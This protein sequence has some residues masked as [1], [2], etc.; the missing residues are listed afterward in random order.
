MPSSKQIISLSSFCPERLNN[1]H[2]HFTFLGYKPGGNDLL[3]FT[4]VS[5]TSKFMDFPLEVLQGRTIYTTLSCE[6]N[7]GLISVMSSNGV[8][9]SNKRPSIENVQVESVPLTTT[10]YN[11]QIPY[12][13]VT[14]NIRLKWS[15]FTDHVGVETYLVCIH[16][17]TL[18]E[19]R[20]M[21]VY[22]EYKNC[23]CVF[24]FLFAV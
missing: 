17:L 4:T 16:V 21:S 10:E 2:L 11:A 24:N 9:I 18:Y 5:T 15:G 8:K 14:D 1:P 3:P 23:T 12:Q 7:A 6:N 13:G 20:R 19:K 22:I